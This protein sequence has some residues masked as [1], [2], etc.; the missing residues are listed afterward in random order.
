MASMTFKEMVQD[1][2]ERNRFFVGL[3]FVSPWLLGLLL[4]SVY[5]LITSLWYSFTRYD[6]IQPP[7]FIGLDNY[8]RTFTRDGRFWTVMYNT[9]YYVF[10]S[11]PISVGT[12][13]LI[14]NL[15]NSQNHRPLDF[16]RDHLYSIDRP[17]RLHRDDLVVF[18]EHPVRCGKL[19][20]TNFGT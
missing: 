11:V 18:T 16:P 13:F 14:A 8:I 19:Y 3:A 9:A 5:P 1:K 17:R 7:V 2:R 4:F 12:A 20:S 10:L 15:L 6:L